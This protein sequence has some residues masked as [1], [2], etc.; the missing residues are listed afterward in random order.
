VGESL[1]F[2]PIKFFDA[3][4]M[5]Y[6]DEKPAVG[7]GYSVVKRMENL[8]RCDICKKKFSSH[9]HL[10]EHCPDTRHDR[11]LIRMRNLWFAVS[12]E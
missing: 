1:K 9:Q 12:T 10:A 2:S 6:S 3:E 4:H 7:G 8:L 5:L 11:Y